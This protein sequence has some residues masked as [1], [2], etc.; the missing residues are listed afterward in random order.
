MTS[1]IRPVARPFQLTADLEIANRLVKSAMS[2]ALADPVTGAPT[3]RLVRLY[4]RLGR[5]GFGLLITGNVCLDLD[6]RTEPGV[7]VLEAERDLPMLRRWAEAAQRHGTKLFMQINHAGRQVPRRVSLRP[8]A[9]SAVPLD[10]LGPLFA[11]PRALEDSEIRELI[12]RWAEAAALAKQAGFAGVQI[13]AAHGYL[14]SQFLSPKTNLRDDRWGGD[15]DGRMR[16]LL[17]IVRAIRARVGDGFPIAVKLN[18]ADF[19]RGGFTEDESA[20]VVRALEA[21]GIDLLEISGGSYESSAMM[22]TPREGAPKKRES[23]RR[24][25]AYFLDY[26]RRIRRE[27]DLPLL[28]TGG[29]RTAEV[30][31]AVIEEGHVDFAGLARPVAVAPDLARE[32]LSGTLDEAPRPQPRVGIRLF[33][34][35]L[36]LAWFQLQL[37]RMGDGLE[38]DPALSKLRTLAHAF[39]SNYL[40]NPLALLRPAPAPR[41]VPPR[42]R[43]A[44]V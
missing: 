39:F 9:P 24:R 34:D 42:A 29:L 38:P 36:Q 4:E 23:T 16:L 17:E 20:A 13:H 26:A 30:I 43:S 40:F 10:G 2:E 14:V 19:Q 33:D 12:R 21:E 28:L 25:E 5:G 31:D 15:L 37:W 1:K 44:R 35:V 11:T 8:I 7:V 18:S 6:G 27:T 32:L 22:G 3:E 41:L